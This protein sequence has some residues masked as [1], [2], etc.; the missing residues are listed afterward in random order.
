MQRLQ[1]R[2][3]ALALI[4]VV[5]LTGGVATAGS[6]KGYGETDFVHTR[7]RDCCE[8]ALALAA[9]NSARSCERAGG[10]ADYDPR[11]LRGSCSSTSRR[12]GHGNS[13]YSCRSSVSV[14]C[15]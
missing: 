13:W 8:D 10:F 11:R 6:Y 7:K 12:D 2:L 15:R 5:T 4:V 1:P 9:E 14:R 3:F